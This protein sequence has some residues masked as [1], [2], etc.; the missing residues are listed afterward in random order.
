MKKVTK[1][2][3]E[4]GSQKLFLETGKV[5][6]QAHGAVTVRYGDTI[7]LATVLSAPAMR[8]IDYFPLYVDY[9]EMQYA[10]GKFPG[11]FF[12]RE[13]RPTSKEVLSCRMIDRTIRPL[14]P[15]DF[16]NEVQI[17]CMV[18]SADK[19]NDADVLAVIGGSAALALSP[20]PFLGPVA[21]V[22][23]GRVDGQFVVFP[24]YK[25]R[26]NSDFDLVVAGHRNAI[27]M[28]EL[29]GNEVDEKTVAQ[30][31][32]FAFEHIKTIIDMI[33][34][35][36]KEAGAEKTYE[37]TPISEELLGLVAD[38]CGEKL[39]QAKQINEKTERNQA[40]AALCDELVAE[41]CPEGAEEAE[42]SPDGVRKAFFKIE[43]KI[44]RELILSGTRPDGRGIDEIRKRTIELS[45]LPR[46]H[47]SALFTRGETQSMAVVTLGTPRDQQKIDGLPEEY[48][49]RFLLHYNFP[50]FSVGEIRPIRGPG[51]RDIGH[52]ALAEKSLQPVLPSA[53]EFPYTVRVVCETLESNGSS[54]MAAVC[55][56]TLSLMDAGVP[57]KEPVAGIS[58]GMVKE[59]G[60]KIL[61]TDI[62]GEEDFHGDM[63]FKVAGSRNGITGIQVDVKPVEG[64]DA[65]TIVQAL[66]KAKS[67]RM[68]LLDDIEQAISAPRKDISTYAPKMITIKIDPEKIGKVIGPGGKTINALSTQYE[69]SIDIE[70]DGTI[71]IAGVSGDGAEK[72]RAEI[73]AMTEEVT[74]GKIYTGKIVGIKE[75][76]AFVEILP[77]QDGLCHISQLENRRVEKVEDACKLGDIMKVKVI[78]IDD[79]GRIKLS[80][81]DA[82]KEEK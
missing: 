16:N 69:V 13:G 2:E 57:I 82:M 1:I 78:G 58:I 8:P 75:F 26:E 48:F 3:K 25:Q 72:A 80:R 5:A 43:G 19:D 15:E 56:A 53:D 79:R 67:A 60:R 59:D 76:G 61:L 63:D 35:I 38:R 14:F 36:T 55:S 64:I 46:T 71:F 70:D 32:D 22:R 9:R 66:E 50:P 40:V 49:K 62:I 39:R 51:R 74:V 30:A 28:I 54:S 11:G 37:S 45:V 29:G 23:V 18:I 33:E 24:T 12:K 17:Q 77:G 52:G 4:I 34:S 81:K 47:G 44:Q 6:K 65:E 42:H 7:V 27:N 31:C 68:Q 21:A 20:A 10:G 73:E 41:I